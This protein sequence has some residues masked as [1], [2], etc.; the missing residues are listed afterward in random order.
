MCRHKEDDELLSEIKE[1]RAK[2]HALEKLLASIGQDIKEAKARAA[3]LNKEAS[4]TR[5]KIRTE[6]NDIL[7]TESDVSNVEEKHCINPFK[8]VPIT[9]FYNFS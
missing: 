4:F 6:S 9:M 3:E 7:T 2:L 8:G 1:R 5:E